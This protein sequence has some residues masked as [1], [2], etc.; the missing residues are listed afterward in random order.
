[1]IENAIQPSGG[2]AYGYDFDYAPDADDTGLLI[3]ILSEFGERYE[4]QIL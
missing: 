3:L 2:I 1:M 4:E